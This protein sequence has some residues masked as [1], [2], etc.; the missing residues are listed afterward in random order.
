MKEEG[1][2]FKFG[3]LFK[4][5]MV[6]SGLKNWQKVLV[7]M[8]P[9]ER[10]EDMLKTQ[11]QQFQQAVTQMTGNGMNQTPPVPQQGQPPVGQA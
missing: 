8:T 11:A 10:Q 9:K 1:Y 3:E 4:E 7:E 6:N 5:G 2:E